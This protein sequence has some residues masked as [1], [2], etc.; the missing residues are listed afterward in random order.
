ME[1]AISCELSRR[2]GITGQLLDLRA[3][4]LPEVKVASARPTRR[5]AANASAVAV[6]AA[7]NDDHADLDLRTVPALAG[8]IGVDAVN[9]DGTAPR[10]LAT[11]APV[12][13]H[14]KEREDPTPEEIE[15]LETVSTDLPA[16]DDSVRMYLRDIG[17]VALL[18]AEEEVVLAKAIEL[19]EQ[20][21]EAPWKGMVSL[22]EWTLHDTEHKTR[23]AML[24]PVRPA[25][26]GPAG[27][28]IYAR[29]RRPS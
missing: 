28:P 26:S 3:G 23:T 17:K 8:V 1:V 21:V 22:H 5:R 11:D 2:D 7:A 14:A 27:R 18:T 9:K 29:I 10:A 20:L 24:Q 15:A 4:S 6:P 19:G 12:T 16:I 25:T 13:L